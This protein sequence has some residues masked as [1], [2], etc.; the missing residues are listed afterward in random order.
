MFSLQTM[1]GNKDKALELL[2]ASADA[3]LEASHAVS[4][5]A[6]G[7]GDGAAFMATFSAARKREKALAAQISE[8]LVNIFV[9]S[10]D[11]EDIEALNAALYR[12]PKTVE[13]FAARYVLVSGHLGGVDFSERTG[14]LATCTEVVADMVRELR[15]GMRIVP[16]RKLQERLQALEG[17]ADRLLLE[18]Y[19]SLYVDGADPIRAT[20]AK[21]LFEILEKAIDK[22]R[23]AGNVIYA[24]VLKNS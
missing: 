23:D 8:A 7:D 20:M 13:K 3:G 24:I 6:R 14:I 16:M 2:E 22:C 21:D 17:E 15:N 11:R 5:L 9:T 19:G 18:P 10:L 12:I 4:Q 1:F